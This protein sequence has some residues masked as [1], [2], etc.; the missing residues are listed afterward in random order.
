MRLGAHEGPKDK[1]AHHT[2]SARN[3]GFASFVRYWERPR[4][5]MNMTSFISLSQH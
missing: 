4:S 5:E 3:P 1:P 2:A